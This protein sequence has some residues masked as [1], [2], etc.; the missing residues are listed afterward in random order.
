MQGIQAIDDAS[1]TTHSECVISGIRNADKV[2]EQKK[3]KRNMYRSFKPKMTLSVD[4]NMYSGS[5]S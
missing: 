5:E 4:A 3:K 2:Y 1:P